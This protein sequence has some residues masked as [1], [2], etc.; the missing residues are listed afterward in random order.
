M[1]KES[2]NWLFTLIEHEIHNSTL[3]QKKSYKASYLHWSPASPGSP[4]LQYNVPRQYSN[5]S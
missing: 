3:F 2:R 1:S 4:S 5:L